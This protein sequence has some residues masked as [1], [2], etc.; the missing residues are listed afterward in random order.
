MQDIY[1]RTECTHDFLHYTKTRQLKTHN[2]NNNNMI[3]NFWYTTKRNID[4]L[5]KAQLC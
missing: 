5:E 2:N 4:K 3:Y 1:E